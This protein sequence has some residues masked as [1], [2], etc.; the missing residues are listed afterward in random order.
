MLTSNEGVGVSVDGGVVVA[1]DDTSTS[2]G[3]V[4]QQVV[5]SHADSL[6]VTTPH[7]SPSLLQLNGP[8]DLFNMWYDITTSISSSGSPSQGDSIRE[9]L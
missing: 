5:C 2:S 1:S 7:L 4:K 3:G 6:G 9:E 8:E